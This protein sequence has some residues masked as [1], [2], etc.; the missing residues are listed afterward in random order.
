M[1][2]RPII[3]EVLQKLAITL[4]TDVVD[5]KEVEFFIF[6]GKTTAWRRGFVLFQLAALSH[7]S[8]MSCVVL[9]E[10][11]FLR[12]M[13]PTVDTRSHRSAVPCTVDIVDKV[14]YTGESLRPFVGVGCIRR[15]QNYQDT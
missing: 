1:T 2:A 10:P 14:I 4:H 8:G 12:A 15:K 13:D 5:F 11:D 3:C 9:K 6:E 7:K